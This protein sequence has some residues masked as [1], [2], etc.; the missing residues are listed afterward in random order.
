MS[1]DQ[2]AIGDAVIYRG[3]TYTFPGEVCGLTD[4]GQVIVR[5]TVAPYTG[6]KHIFGPSQLERGNFVE[7]AQPA[8]AVTVKALE[9][10]LHT[11]G[12][13]HA[14]TVVGRYDVGI[15]HAG[16]TAI[17]R[18]IDGA[19]AHDTVLVRGGGVEEAKSAGQA[20]Y[21]RRILSALEHAA[22]AAEPVTTLKAYIHRLIYA[23]DQFAAF[24]DT[25]TRDT[26]DAWV[27]D[28]ARWKVVRDEAERIALTAAPKHGGG[29]E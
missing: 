10:H 1:Q 15:V 16:F 17:R 6:M 7:A 2:F 22:P 23:G 8:G 13:W 27:N 4:D 18:S 5:A 25:Q 28:R 29:H 3:K 9:W 26:A 20:D 12:D 24:D 21:E 19:N 14:E 11:S